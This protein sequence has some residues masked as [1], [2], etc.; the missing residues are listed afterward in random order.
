M[1]II[2]GLNEAQKQALLQ[3]E[4]A[5]LVSAGA[6]S[7]KTRL[8]T[9]RIAYLIQELGVK[10]DEIIAI[11]FTN[12]AAR[13]M[14]ERVNSLLG[15]SNKVWVSTFHSMC[16]KMLREN[17]HSLE[18]FSSSFSIYND[19]DSEKL[20]KDI[21]KQYGWEDDLKKYAFHISN[22]KN[23][24]QE[25]AEYV[26]YYSDEQK[27]EN[28]VKVFDE[29]QQKLK[30][31]NALDF[32]DLLTKTYELL[33]TAPLVRQYYTNKF[34]YIL[35]D[36]F[37]DTN[38]VQ[39]DLIKLLSSVHG[40]VFAVGDED[41]CI[42][43]WRGADF[44]NIIDFKSY[45]KNCKVFKLEQNYRSTKSILQLA[46]KV[47]QNN[48]ERLNKNLWTDNKEGR[49]VEYY[50]Q[51]DEQ[52]E[53]ESVVSKII[54]LVKNGYKYSDIAILMRLNA[55]S[56]PFEQKLLAYNIPHQIYGGF[57][58]YER[59]EIKNIIAYL[60]LFV[61]PQDE[62]SLLRVIN[63]PK[64]GIGDGA[65]AKLQEF[66]YA[67]NLSL[68]DSILML[69]DY[70][71]EDIKLS[72]K[73]KPFGDIYKEISK[74]YGQ[75]GLEN[76]VKSVISKFEIKMAYATDSC[77]DED[78]IMNIDA[79][80][81]SVKQ[82]EDANDN[83]TL[84]DYLESITLESDIDH[85]DD[86][87]NVTIATIHAV[88]G[89]EF[90]VV[91]VVGLEEGIFPI[92]RSFNSKS[93]LEEERRLMYVAMTRAE[94]RL[95]LSSADT[96]Y[97]Y[98]KRSYIQVSRFVDEAGLKHHKDYS[99]LFKEAPTQKPEPF[100][101]QFKKNITIPKPQSSF[102][103]TTSASTRFDDEPEQETNANNKYKIGQKVNHPKFGFG[104]IV[105]IVDNGQC[106]DIV[107]EAFGKKTLILEIAPLKIID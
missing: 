11:T 97:L 9:H 81:G 18:G 46:N 103:T 4:G 12:K 107:F 89:L 70:P 23:K 1:G 30:E 73:F 3:T 93:E 42:Y 94:E 96:R 92:S 95:F 56:L 41:Q 77:D 10:D 82:Y 79:F 28:I 76:F 45:F 100:Y 50:G 44:K 106:A 84:S 62:V 78:K 68:L 19:T 58:F 48:S 104:E 21:L 64:R 71:L 55:L 98:G 7:G 27:A 75:V 47:I 105:D 63:F 14:K 51:Y 86:S 57:K 29:Y 52:A 39:Y 54:A 90:K 102:K 65:L 69:T 33:S 91:F 35:V 32:D 26:K 38:A 72:A 66:S 80:V 43:S 59:Q 13:E 15:Y 88:K 22:C 53:A 20:L 25:V 24:N 67:K 8:L 60:R 49:T 17:I 83:A 87:E 85:M 61:N 37:Q 5:V 16:A 2:D 40:N 101:N 36:E 99:H 31:C 74:T 34:R 6:G